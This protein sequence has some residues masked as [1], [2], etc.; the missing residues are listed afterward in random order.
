MV[1]GSVSEQSAYRDPKRR[2]DIRTAVKCICQHCL[3]VSEYPENEFQCRYK[4]GTQQLNPK[5]PT[6]AN[7]TFFFNF[8]MS[9]KILRLSG[10]KTLVLVNSGVGSVGGGIYA[11]L[12]QG[13]SYGF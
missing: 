3:R 6:K 1:S 5:R 2:Q 13:S 10:G 11:G 9:G 8:Q 4:A 12:S 7:F